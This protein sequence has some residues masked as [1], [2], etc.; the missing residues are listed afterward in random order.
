[1]GDPR[2]VKC[3]DCGVKEGEIHDLGC[4][5]ERCPFCGGQLISCD[6]R[7][8]LLNV[9]VSPGTYAYSHGLTEIKEKSWLGVL[10]G[11]GRVPYILWPNLCARCG[12]LWPE[13]FSV[14]DAEWKR[15]VQKR[16]RGCMLC[17]PCYDEIKH[18]TDSAERLYRASLGV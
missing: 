15:Y 7:Y 5:M 18:L 1:M 13:M 3:H 2:E 4:D 10:G 8:K 17:R 9:D 6:C 12:K 11:A 16:K 14:P